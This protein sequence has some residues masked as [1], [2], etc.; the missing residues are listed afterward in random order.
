MLRL[1]LLILLLSGCTP[2]RDLDE[3][4]QQDSAYLEPRT[5]EPYSGPVYRLFGDDSTKI[6]IEGTLRDGVWHGD[7]TVFHQNGRVRYS[8]A[9]A[10]GTQCGPWTENADPEPRESLYEEFVLEIESLSV[11]P[12]CPEGV[13]AP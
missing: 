7:L 4:V 1:A 10:N 2:V 3:L 11:Y 12:P 6:E 5:M 13:E 9:L 8:G